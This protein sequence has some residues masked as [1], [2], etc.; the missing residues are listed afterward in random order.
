MVVP[1]VSPKSLLGSQGGFHFKQ[2]G[3][4]DM[5][6]GLVVDRIL[7]AQPHLRKDS[8]KR[9]PE[10]GFLSRVHPADACR[11]T[12]QEPYPLLSSEFR[13]LPSTGSEVPVRAR[14]GRAGD[15]SG[16]HE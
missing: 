12:E 14:K 9:R 11:R 4:M 5:V 1:Q 15:S 10:Y 3:K 8:S 7:L 16:L 2:W 6:G 13:A